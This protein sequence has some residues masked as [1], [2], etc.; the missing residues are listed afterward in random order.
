M[1]VAEKMVHRFLWDQRSTLWIDGR[2]DAVH[3]PRC[4]KRADA[5]GPLSSLQRSPNAEIRPAKTAGSAEVAFP[6]VRRRIVGRR[7]IAG[8]RRLGRLRGRGG[9]TCRRG[10]ERRGGRISVS[11]G[12]R[13]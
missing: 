8:Q 7:R 12:R 4:M 5:Q 9:R 1:I 3:N 11:G 10:R 2:P 13:W 6:G